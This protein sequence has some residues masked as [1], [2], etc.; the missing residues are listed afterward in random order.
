MPA[1]L[2]QK[3][4]A[5]SFPVVIASDQSAVP[6]SAASLPLPAGAATEAT[7]ATR[8]ADATITAR[9]NTLGQKAMA[10]SA[11][12]V[13]ASDQSA[14][15]VTGP[16]T[17]AQL[18]AS[19]V[20][21]SAAALPLP[22]GAATEATLATRA[23]EATLA[24]RLSEADF[25]TKT[26]SLTEAAPA[27]DTA[28]SGLNG[29]L[30]R[31]A[32]RLTSLI[33]LLPAALVGGRLDTN[34]GAWLGSTTPTVGQKAMAASLPV[35][36]ASDQT[37]VLTDPRASVLSITVTGGANA[38]ATATLPA[39]GAGL[40]H[41]I[42]HVFIKRVATAAL[43]GGA[44]LTVT[45]TNLNARAWRTGNQM[46]ITVATQEGA[47]LMDQEFVHPIKSAVANTASTIVGPAAGAAVSWHMVVEYF[48]A[49]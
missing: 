43:A 33:A 42:T 28:S 36:I 9:L 19:A 49:T 3:V 47:V 11:P 34:I 12:V 16:L 7:L 8:V 14:I 20:P 27:T 22:A 1:S 29:R 30:Q 31:I 35:T 38:I 17:D 5:A 46:S 40:F 10:A 13:I 26:G 25:D 21:V 32:Q 18:R 23:T 44:L 2:G 39:A 45:T 37:P 4:M 48:T 6:I 15:A 41:Y 24:T